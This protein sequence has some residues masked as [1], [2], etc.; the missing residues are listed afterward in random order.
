MIYRLD[1]IQLGVLPT[2][3]SISIHILHYKLNSKYSGKGFSGVRVTVFIPAHASSSS[4][5]PWYPGTPTPSCWPTAWPADAI[6]H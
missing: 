1:N 6:H 5:S 4:R 3:A 2:S